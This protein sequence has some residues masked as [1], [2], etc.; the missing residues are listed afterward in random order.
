MI[1][2]VLKHLWRSFVRGVVPLI[3]VGAALTF[4]AFTVWRI[5]SWII[6]FVPHPLGNLV[7]LVLILIAATLAMCAMYAVGNAIRECQDCE[8][9]EL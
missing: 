5:V 7:A 8:G 1:W 2:C 9:K 6:Y 4:V 3:I